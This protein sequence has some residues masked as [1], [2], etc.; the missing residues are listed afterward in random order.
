[1]KKRISFFLLAAGIVLAGI[2]FASN[3]IQA[4]TQKLKTTVKYVSTSQVK[5]SWKKPKTKASK[6]VIYRAASKKEVKKPKY[7]KYKTLKSSAVSF[8]DKKLKMGWHY[9][10]KI[11]G[12]NKRGKT[13]TQTTVPVNMCPQ[14]IIYLETDISSDYEEI[15]VWLDDGIKASGIMVYRKDDT[16]KEESFTKVQNVKVKNGKTASFTDKSLIPY[17]WYTYKI[18]SYIKVGKKYYYGKEYRETI[19][20]NAKKDSKYYNIS[21][22]RPYDPETDTLMIRLESITGNADTYLY[23]GQ[24]SLYSNERDENGL[25]KYSKDFKLK[26]MNYDGSEVFE[27]VEKR[28]III[29]EEETV[30]LLFEGI[31]NEA[32]DPEKKEDTGWI[33]DNSDLT[34]D[35]FDNDSDDP[36][37]TDLWKKNK[38]DEFISEINVVFSADLDRGI[39]EQFIEIMDD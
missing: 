25:P 23:T 28:S 3:T 39:A 36:A 10:Y 38:G 14:E 6:Y 2:F 35:C 8:Q 11:C 31:K 15:S 7:K 32:E 24:Y 16:E 30:Y 26:G 18:K 1:M 17:H 21:M 29:K 19:R 34:F 9:Y 20:A 33:T 37:I 4:K 13:L 5:I 22:E 12:L 27:P